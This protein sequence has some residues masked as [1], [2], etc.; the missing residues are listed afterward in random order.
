MKGYLLI[1]I[2]FITACT[3]DKEVTYESIDSYPIKTGNFW[4]YSSVS[5]SKLYESEFS[6][7]LIETDTFRNNY[8]VRIEKDTLLN[9]TI[10]VFQI[11]SARIGGIYKKSEYCYWDSTGFHTYAYSTGGSHV[12]PKKE[13]E[14]TQIEMGNESFGVFGPEFLV[15]EDI[16]VFPI[17]RHNLKFPLEIPSKWTYTFPYAPYFLQIDKEIIGYENIKIENRIFSCYKIKWI[18]IEN[19]FFDGMTIFD[20]VSSEGLI[21]RE[22]IGGRAR[23]TTPDGESIGSSQWTETIELTNLSISQ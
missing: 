1:A 17:S 9:D 8:I 14:I 2:I 12:L 18:Y 11:T 3:Y 16:S 19:K 6:N 23:L 15:D 21:K 10:N 20:W 5:I 22:I 4:E 13:F 7:K